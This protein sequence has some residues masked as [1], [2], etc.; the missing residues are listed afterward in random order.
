MIYPHKFKNFDEYYNCIYNL[1]NGYLK[2]YI[3][4]PNIKYSV[5]I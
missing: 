2:K 4:D 5:L 3:N 1:M